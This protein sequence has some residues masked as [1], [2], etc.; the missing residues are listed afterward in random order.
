V[1]RERKTQLD[2]IDLGVASVLQRAS[3]ALYT[4]FALIVL[5]TGEALLLDLPETAQNMILLGATAALIALAL[6]LRQSLRQVERDQ[7]AAQERTESFFGLSL[8][9]LCTI[10]QANRLAELNPS[11]TRVLG[12]SLEE[13]RA[14]PAI[15]FVHPD[16]RQ[17][18]IELSEIALT[19]GKEGTVLENRWQTYDGDWRWLSWSLRT[20]NDDVKLYGRATDVTERKQIEE[21]L[22]FLARH[23]QLTGLAN[24]RKFEEDLGR[25]LARTRRYGWRGALISVD[26]DGLKSV[27]DT[28][29]H[30][31]GD[32]LLRLAA[33][34]MS[35]VLRTSDLLAR[36][37]GDEFAILLPEADPL[38]ARAVAEKIARALAEPEPD[39][40]APVASIGVATIEEQIGA[41]EL[42]ARADRALYAAKRA[43]GG[44]FR[45]A[46]E[47]AA[48]PAPSR[49][50]EQRA[51]TPQALI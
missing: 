22:H 5:G 6:V 42:F 29:G 49:S 2:R 38:N 37:G 28:R 31:A 3:L 39:G 1:E 16:D 51:R 12:W 34:R 30:A 15:E 43:S 4:I 14:R 13:L 17:R 7:R 47:R 11:W 40:T 20:G 33:Q 24:R 48:G 50:G 46:P 27:N 32:A 9:M 8:D 45:L 25:H 23:D 35:R 44:T 26:L 21:E 10:D 18:T 36:L 19:P 41:E